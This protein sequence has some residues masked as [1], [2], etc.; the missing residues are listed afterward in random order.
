MKV[1]ILWYSWFA[2]R[3]MDI[4]HRLAIDVALDE[5][6]ASLNKLASA[7]QFEGGTRT[8]RYAIIASHYANIDKD[9]PGTV[10]I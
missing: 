4:C 3:S 5:D 7:L 10:E 1:H 9:L 8:L 6:S 2:T